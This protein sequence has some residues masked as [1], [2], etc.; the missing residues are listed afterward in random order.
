MKDDHD[1]ENPRVRLAWGRRGGLREGRRSGAL[2]PE[3]GDAEVTTVDVLLAIDADGQWD[4]LDPQLV[5]HGLREI[6]G[7]VGDDADAIGAHEA[8]RVAGEA[9]R[10]FFRDERTCANH[11]SSTNPNST[12]VMTLPMPMALTR[13]SRGTVPP[14]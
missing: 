8:G 6:A 5:G 11:Q 7:R 12:P 2:R 13:N 9:S 1:A 14:S 10:R 4:D 3:L